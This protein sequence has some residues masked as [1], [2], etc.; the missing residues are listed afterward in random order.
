[1]VSIGSDEYAVNLIKVILLLYIYIYIYLHITY[2]VAY[3]KYTLLSVVINKRIKGQRKAFPLFSLSIN[4]NQFKKSAVNHPA[5]RWPRSPLSLFY[6]LS[7]SGLLSA[8]VFLS[9]S[10]NKMPG[11]NAQTDR[12]SILWFVVSRPQIGGTDQKAKISGRS[13]ELEE[14]QFSFPLASGTA[15]AMSQAGR[16]CPCPS[17]KDLPKH[18]NFTPT[19]MTS[20]AC[21]LFTLGRWQRQAERALVWGQHELWKQGPPMTPITG[22]VPD[23]WQALRK[24]KGSVFS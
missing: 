1:M 21:I 18:G 6:S 3:L 22:T 17:P 20:I 4:H 10:G 19:R 2:N 23:A 7:T 5:S 8:C 14:S 11:M 12:F 9:Q 15:A 24:P 16:G 13:K